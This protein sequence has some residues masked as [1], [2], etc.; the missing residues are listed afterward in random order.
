MGTCPRHLPEARRR[1]PM[2]RPREPGFFTRTIPP[3][4]GS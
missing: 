3:F 2:P 1:H 4:H